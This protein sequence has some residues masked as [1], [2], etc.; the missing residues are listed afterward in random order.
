MQATPKSAGVLTGLFCGQHTI[1]D[2]DVGLHSKA[3][4]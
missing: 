4:A 3:L 2:E 1:A